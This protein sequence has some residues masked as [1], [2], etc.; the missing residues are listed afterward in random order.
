[1]CTI[2]KIMVNI[3]VMI[4]LI[5][6]ISFLKQSKVEQYLVSYLPTSANLIWSYICLL[7]Q[8]WGYTVLQWF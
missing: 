4:E 3:I 2:E 7:M 1:M 8:T 6:D 5:L